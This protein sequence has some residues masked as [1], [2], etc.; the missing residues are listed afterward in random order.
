M[1]SIFADLAEI[2]PSLKKMNYEKKSQY[3]LKM[4]LIDLGSRFNHAI[5]V[6]NYDII[7]EA[8]KFYLKQWKFVKDNRD[9]A[10]RNYVLEE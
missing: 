10:D 8:T 7:F 6:N 3:E 5:N 9:K 1:R 4:N 2:A